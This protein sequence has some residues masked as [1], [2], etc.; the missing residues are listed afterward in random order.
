MTAL[1]PSYGEL[2][3]AL[4]D[5]HGVCCWGAS[6]RKTLPGAVLALQEHCETCTSYEYFVHVQH[7]SRRAEATAACGELVAVL[8][9]ASWH[10][11]TGGGGWLAVST[12]Y[13]QRAR[14]PNRPSLEP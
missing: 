12:D 11:L 4:G 5:G 7:Q 9:R 8:G 2:V 6:R 1:S 13:E 3:W 10:R 14:R